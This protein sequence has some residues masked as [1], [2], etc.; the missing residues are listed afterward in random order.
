MRSISLLLA[1]L[2]AST[3]TA[4]AQKELSVTVENP[5]KIARTDYPVVIPVRTYGDMQQAVVTLN[6]KEIPS[7][8][9]DL[10]RDGYY[11]E[12]CFL[13]DIDKKQKQEYKVKLLSSGEPRSYKART[14]AEIVLRNPKVKE[15]NKHDLYLSEITATKDLIDQY[16]LLHHHGVAF[17]S[18]LIGI[19]IYFDKRQTLDLYGKKQKGL[20]IKDTQFYTSKEQK[21]AG[22]GDDVLW[23]GNT[24]GLGAL[25][26]WDGSQPTMIDDVDHRTQRIIATGPVRTIIE[27]VDRGWKICD[28]MPKVNATIRYTLYGGHRDVNVDVSFNRKVSDKLFSTGIIN[29]KGSDEFT[30]KKGLRGCWGTAFPSSEKD[31]VEHPRETVGLGIYIPKPYLSQELEANADNYG[32]VIKP[33]DNRISYSLV[34]TS[35]NETFGCGNK[36]GWF[37]YLRKWRKELE[38]PLKTQIYDKDNK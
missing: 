20:E 17:E 8:L 26:G 25:R 14:F 1:T 34:Y 29:V 2:L 13:A 27:M 28:N 19:R 22:Y 12:L 9:D 10:D 21:E 18:E 15:K 37:D 36:D 3:M 30:D 5:S 7:Q 11:D 6:G 33:A 35:A 4:N 31:S 23:V 38:S 16:H 24:F 32:Y